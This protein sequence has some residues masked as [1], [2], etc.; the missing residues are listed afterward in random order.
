MQ[1]FTLKRNIILH[2]MEYFFIDISFESEDLF[3][4]TVL[5]MTESKGLKGRINNLHSWFLIGLNV[6]DL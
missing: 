2:Q 4:E 1:C 5:V 6:D 3:S